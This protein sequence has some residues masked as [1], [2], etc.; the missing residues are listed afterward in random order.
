MGV[1]P[2]TSAYLNFTLLVLI[3]QAKLEVTKAAQ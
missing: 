3:L 2:T 1:A